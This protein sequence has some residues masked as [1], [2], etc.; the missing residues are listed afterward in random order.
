MDKSKK[1]ELS[2]ESSKKVPFFARYLVEQE[3]TSTRGGRGPDGT[4]K[5]PSDSDDEDI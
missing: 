5:F 3:L 4:L 1:P 2:R